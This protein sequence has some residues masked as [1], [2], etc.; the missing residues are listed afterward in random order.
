MI[1]D[2]GGSMPHTHC[3]GRAVGARLRSLRRQAGLTQSDL[4]RLLGTTQSAVAR[5]EGGGQRLNLDY[6][7]RVAGVL[8]CDVSVVIEQRK[9]A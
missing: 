4:A 8:D 1:D 7:R 5:M 9:T 3:E 2:A 6:L